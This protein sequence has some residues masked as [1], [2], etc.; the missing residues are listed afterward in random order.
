M[1][2]YD[3]GEGS[4]TPEAGSRDYWSHFEFDI[5]MAEQHTQIT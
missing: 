2:S 5:I 3:L 4:W 1:C